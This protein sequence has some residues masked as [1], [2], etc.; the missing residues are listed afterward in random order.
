MKKV[1]IAVVVL[2]AVL[3]GV[4]ASR[5]NTFTVSRSGTMAAP[6]E[7]AFAQIADFHKWDAWSPWSKMDP[8]MKVTYE[9]TPGTVGSSYAWKGNDDVGSGKMTITGLTPPSE[10]KINLEFQEPFPS[11]NETVFTLKPNGANTEVTWTMSGHNSFMSKAFGLFMDMDKMIGA[12]FEKGLAA[13]KTVAEA[14]AKK[15]AEAKAAAEA[16]AAAAAQP[17]TAEGDAAPGASPAAEGD[18]AAA[19][20][21]VADDTMK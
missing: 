11:T 12:D 17:A 4:I 6:P 1:L 18:S 5:P 16:A 9:G 15:A 20:A 13:M 8:Q 19:P 21:Q 14:E 2:L 3:A 10:V 7:I